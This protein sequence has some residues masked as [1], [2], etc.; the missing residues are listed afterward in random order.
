PQKSILAVADRDEILL[1][2]VEART[3][4][5]KLPANQQ[6]PFALR[7]SVDGSKLASC[8][9]GGIVRVRDSK[10][11]K[12]LLN[13]DSHT[14]NPYAV[15]FSPDLKFAACEGQ[16]QNTLHVW[17][18]AT[19]KEWKR[20]GR[21]GG[22]L[23]SLAFSPDGRSLLEAGGTPQLFMWEIATGQQRRAKA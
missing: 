9:Q 18:L 12:E 8:D 16:E 17:D 7:F 2:D 4:V 6:S 15:A 21:G 22:G 23:L 11:G 20:F 3:L 5:R 13:F 1:W 14:S 19:G 10:T